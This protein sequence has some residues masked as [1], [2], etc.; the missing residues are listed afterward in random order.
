MARHANRDVNATSATQFAVA[1]LALAVLDTVATICIKEAY[2]RRSP[3][4][5]LIGAGLFVAVAYVEL[6]ALALASLTLVVLGWIVTLQV[7]VT[8]VDRVHY[9]V[10]L[11]AIQSIALTVSLGAAVVAVAAAPAGTQ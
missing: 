8:A 11:S 7:V 6:L 2:V 3:G 4:I 9:G 5:A 10:R 1:I